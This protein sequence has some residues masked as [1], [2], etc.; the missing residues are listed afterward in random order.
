DIGR[1]SKMGEAFVEIY[2]EILKQVVTSAARV[3]LKDVKLDVITKDLP[4]MT[5]K[6]GKDISK[7][8]GD[9]F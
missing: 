9:L 3:N 4:D 5:K 6:I 8:I 7:S 2:N 1:D